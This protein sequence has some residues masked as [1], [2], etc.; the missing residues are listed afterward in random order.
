MT[1]LIIAPYKFT[2]LLTQYVSPELPSQIIGMEWNDHA[3]GFIFSS[4]FC[5][6]ILLSRV[7]STLTRDIDIAILSVRLSVTFWY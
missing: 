1:F 6:N 4:F 2:Y 5:L 7:S 3:D